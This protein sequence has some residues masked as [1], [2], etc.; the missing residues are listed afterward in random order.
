MERA[1]RFLQ[2]EL[3][4]LLHACATQHEPRLGCRT[5]ASRAQQDELLLNESPEAPRGLEGAAEAG[6][7]PGASSLARVVGSAPARCWEG[8]R[9]GL[10]EA[11]LSAVLFQLFISTLPRLCTSH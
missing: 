4:G 3:S 8:S 10:K 5:S 1:L 11:G 2:R 9:R 6:I 7:L